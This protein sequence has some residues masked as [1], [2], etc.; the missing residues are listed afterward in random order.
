MDGH[1]LIKIEMRAIGFV[2]RA[3]P[4]ENDRDR[5]LVA[6]IVI[7]Q[8]LAPAL[9]G[10][11]DWSHIYVIFWM[12]RVEHKEE[13]VLHHTNRDL[14]IFA[15]RSPIHPNPFGL[16]L[17]ELVKREENVLW[18]RGLDAYD[19]TPVLDIKPYPDWEKGLIV[20]TDFRIPEW[21]RRII[22]GHEG[23]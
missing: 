7:N 15:A 4:D 5:S 2:S 12:D 22:E 20:V 3:S 9:D 1:E 10:I 19:G 17:V 21:L 23:G 6:K 11:E 14:G 18:V 16:T 8:A 13:P